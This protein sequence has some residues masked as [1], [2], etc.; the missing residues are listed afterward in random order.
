[1]WHV[2]R[3]GEYASQLKIAELNASDEV[4]AKWKNEVLLGALA[5]GELDA[6]MAAA[7]KDSSKK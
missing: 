4:E 6:V 3:H 1:L 5:T 2:G 7:D